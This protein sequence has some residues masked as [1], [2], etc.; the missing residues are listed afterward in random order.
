MAVGSF[1]KR[2]ELRKVRGFTLVELLTVLSILAILAAILFP[3]LNKA[4]ET[5]N[6]VVCLSNMKQLGDGLNMYLNDNN[7][8]FP[9]AVPWGR[10]SFWHMAVNGDQSTI[11]ELLLPYVRNGMLPDGHGFYQ[12]IGVFV[13]PSDTGLPGNYAEL[14]GV[15]PNQPL[16]KYTGCS[17]EYYANNQED[18]QEASSDT[19]GNI[20][21]WTALSP[22]VQGPQGIER[23]GAPLSKIL[24]PSRKAVLGDAWFWHE[25]DC[26][27][28]DCLAYRN[29]LFADGHA[30]RARGN[31]YLEA[32]IQ[33]LEPWHSYVEI[34]E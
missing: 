7:A 16:W 30:A 1:E 26:V 31:E 12:K 19:G 14:N 3:V 25:G 33:Q 8:C 28:V 18:W 24:Y 29:T 32:R 5:A 23:I 11:Q 13:C 4:K 15:P 9:P 6:I 10:P 34:D 20:V 21:P 2:P 22:E 17:Y 27:P